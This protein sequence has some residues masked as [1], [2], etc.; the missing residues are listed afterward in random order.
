MAVIFSSCANMVPPTGGQ[1]DITPPML[2]KSNPPFRTIYFD[3]DEIQLEF[4]EL[5]NLESI[6]SQLVVSPPLQEKPDVKFMKKK[7]TV[8]F[9]DEVLQENTTYT[10]NFGSAIVDHNAGNVLKNFTYVFS[11]GAYIDS[12]SVEG[13]VIDSFT[14]E[15]VEDMVVMLY[16]SN[17]DSL[18][19]NT[20]PNYFGMSDENGMYS[21]NNIKEGNYKVFAVE[22]VNQN[23]L[24][25]RPEERIAFFS[26]MIVLDSS[27]IGVDM[28]AFSEE[29]NSQFIIKR[30]K[31]KYGKLRYVFNRPLEKFEVVLQDEVFSK[32]EYKYHVS[33]RR[34]SLDFWFPDYEGEFT[35]M[36]KGDS[37]FSDT[38]KVKVVPIYSLDDQP[39]FMISSNVQGLVDLNSSLELRFD[40]PI[41]I[42]KPEF[43]DLYEDS[44]KVEI[45]PVFSDSS[46][47]LVKIPYKWKEKAKYIL[48]VG[49]GTFVDFYE[50]GNEI[51]ELKFGAQEESFYGKINMQID[52]DSI[53]PPFIFNL[54][55]KEKKSLDQKTLLAS[56]EINYDFLR[57][58]DYSFRLIQD[59]NNNGKWDSGNYFKK[60]QPE[61]VIYYPSLT[62]VR[63]NWEI[64]L[65][66]EINSES[67]KQK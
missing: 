67:L 55:D 7:I 18:P 13:K 27:L 65:S 30:D 41:E 33:K 37:T 4:D 52:I 17:E 59:L 16:R 36:V 39:E 62:N 1:K 54:L 40:N 34:D 29:S 61:P 20:L 25:D 58:V 53:Q 60:R 49:L 51:Y 6:N 42:M 32:E 22:D 11:T 47:L 8:K 28:Q 66:W 64:D 57:P 24:Y 56:K 44:V 50:L 3:K 14:K 12:I 15:P 23:Y 43:I 35:L 10:F 19:L 21:I 63:S 48:R 38:S 46:K 9:K 26:E 2:K 31:T 45:K 5:I